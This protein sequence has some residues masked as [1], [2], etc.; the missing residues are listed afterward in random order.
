MF[1]TYDQWMKISL[2]DIKH[3]A[4]SLTNDIAMTD[5]LVFCGKYLGINVREFF[6]NT[7]KK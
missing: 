4:Q 3:I 5:F 7:P 2:N 6:S 1:E